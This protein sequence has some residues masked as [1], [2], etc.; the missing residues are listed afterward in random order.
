MASDESKSKL[1]A[2]GQ[3]IS[4]PQVRYAITGKFTA[5][6]G[7]KQMG[8][9]KSYVPPCTLNLTN[10]TPKKILNRQ[11]LSAAAQALPKAFSWNNSADAKSKGLP[12]NIILSPGNQ[13][14]C[15]SC[16]AW[17]VS[18]SL[19]DRMSIKHGSNPALGP[20]YLL[21]CSV[22]GTCDKDNLSGCN[23]G[24]I[25]KALDA[26][27]K[28]IGGVKTKCWNYSW[29]DR[30]SGDG[31][32]DN[33]LIP[34][35]PSNQDKCVSDPSTKPG[36]FKV[37]DGSV[38][39]LSGMVEDRV[40]YTAI[41]ESIFSNGPIPTGYIVFQ[42]FFMGTADKS[43]G[44]DNWAPTKGVYVHL[45]TDNTG[46]TPEGDSS[47]YK[48]GSSSDMN[49]QA[50]AHAVVIVGWGEAE[51]PNIVPKA[52]AK[53]NPGSPV[54]A[55]ITIPYWVVR[56]SWGTNWCEKGFFR[57]AQTNP[58]FHIGTTVFFDQA[59]AGS[60]GGVIDFHPDLTNVPKIQRMRALKSGT[61]SSDSKRNWTIAVIIV[62]II[63]GVVVWKKMRQ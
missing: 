58:D 8:P 9:G 19:S 32:T 20:S 12:G 26:L 16:W 17:A 27:I 14:Q 53:K 31:D 36:L 4:I 41:K 59:A 24:R 1:F 28:P 5:P 30:C 21:A 55:K 3:I 15:G 33:T 44:G 48:Y 34:S 52:W 39:T 43:Q 7:E 2:S 49:T 35:F 37:K 45:D 11:M 38:Q 25:D 42:D 6:R 47:P 54:P 51:I 10:S 29:C 50:G 23:G 46:V 61:D 62:L 22:T 18:T 56:N 60:V 40:D 57:I 63:I 13:L